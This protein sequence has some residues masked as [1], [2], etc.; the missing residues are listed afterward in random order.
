MG[1]NKLKRRSRTVR[2]K[3][4]KSQSKRPRSSKPL[5]LPKTSLPKSRPAKKQI[6]TRRNRASRLTRN[7]KEIRP[8]EMP[9][10]GPKTASLS[11]RTP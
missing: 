10:K 9:Q 5:K 4:L 6:Q 8:T 1:T 11:P 3:V 7:Q 2:K